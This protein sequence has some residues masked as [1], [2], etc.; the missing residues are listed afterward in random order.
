MK[1]DNFS[2]NNI[3]K[4]RILFVI[5][6]IFITLFIFWFYSRYPALMSKSEATL[7]K[8]INAPIVSGLTFSEYLH[9]N[10][11]SL[12]KEIF[13]NTINWIASNIKWMSFWIIF[14]SLFMTLLWLLK[15][16]PKYF[17]FKGIKWSFMWASIWLPLWVCANCV[18]PIWIWMWNKG[19]QVSYVLSM[20][21]SSPLLN[22]IALI[23]IFS[24]FSF[25]AFV[26]RLFVVLLLIL[27]FIPCIEKIYNKN[28][29]EHISSSNKSEYIEETYISAF[30]ESWK[31]SIKNLLYISK[32]TI[33]LMLLAW[34]LWSIMI[35][36]FPFNITD[37][38]MMDNMK[39]LLLS[40][41]W[42]LFIGL[43][44]PIPILFDVM[45]ATLLLTN[46]VP[47]FLLI[48][49]M[50][51]LWGTS[52]FPFILLYKTYWFKLAS[53]HVLWVFLAWLLSGII[54]YI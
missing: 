50:I 28:K 13:K 16:F 3:Y 21:I 22:P 5:I 12:L 31:V 27:I 24:F 47:E 17:S 25:E 32:L 2:E 19:V 46:W 36:L 35:T 43:F 38:H 48:P 51:V 7:Y 52:I 6:Y 54:L 30:I 26:V 14:W 1:L 29:S 40:M 10:Y 39:L 44:V 45:F 49:L 42:T 8:I 34:F 20:M 23:M 41:I 53:L 11:D 18:A 9:S 4:K 15:V 33:P 37:I